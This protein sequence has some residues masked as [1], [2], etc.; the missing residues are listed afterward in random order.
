MLIG[1]PNILLEEKEKE[2][3][4][5]EKEE[6]KEEKKEKEKKKKRTKKKKKKKK[7]PLH[8]HKPASA[9]SSSSRKIDLMPSLI[10]CQ[11]AFRCSG[12]LL[13]L[14]D[15]GGSRNTDSPPTFSTKNGSSSKIF[16]FGTAL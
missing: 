9:S 7:I 14:S 12:T 4:E 10:N 15:A 6:E 2:K 13:T 5:K 16:T 3:E 8:V 1:H 11:S